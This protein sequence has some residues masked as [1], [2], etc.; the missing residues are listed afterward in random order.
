MDI[1]RSIITRTQV[2]KSTNSLPKT[3]RSIMAGPRE[4]SRHRRK[5]RQ[6]EHPLLNIQASH[7]RP[8]AEGSNEAGE[9]GFVRDHT[10]VPSAHSEDSYD[11][12]DHGHPLDSRA[13]RL[14]R[15]F[16]KTCKE[17]LVKHRMWILPATLTCILFVCGLWAF[18]RSAEPS[19]Y[20]TY[21]STITVTPSST[22]Y[23]TYTVHYKQFHEARPVHH[24]VPMAVPSNLEATGQVTGQDLS[25]PQIVTAT[26][27]PVSGLY[28]IP[29]SVASG[30]WPQTQKDSHPSSRSARNAEGSQTLQG[31]PSFG[32]S[33]PDDPLLLQLRGTPR[34]LFPGQAYADTT[35]FTR[36]GVEVLYELRRRSRRSIYFNKR[37]CI[38]SACSPEKILNSMCNTNKTIS[39]S[40]QKQEC[41]WCWPENQRKHQEINKHCSKVSKH[42]LNTMFI[43]CGIFLFCT[44]AIAIVLATRMLRRRRRAEA[45]C[46]LHKH[47]STIPQE[48]TNSAPSCWVSLDMTNSGR[49]SKAKKTRV[50]DKA[51]RKRS[52]GEAVG[53]KSWYKAVFAKWGKLSGTGPANPAHARLKLQKKETKPLD[54][55]FA[56]GDGDH[57]RVPVLP[58]AP[59][60]ISSQFF[61]D[62]ENMGQGSLR[63][64]PGI[65]NSQ[66]DPLVMPLRS[67][68]QSRAF[69]SGSEQSSSVATNR[70]DVG[71]GVYNLERLTERK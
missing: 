12:H 13:L 36:W 10:D 68:R 34:N 32:R 22:V 25:H 58:P 70:G 19:D 29:V 5:E 43:I 27:A 39:D 24:Q 69:S 64:D 57:E 50:D 55:D 67:S 3:R 56:I 1:H 54:Q 15:R 6:E 66:H 61:S 62:I 8:T 48:K 16:L 2:P 37:S 42:A 63:S 45:D 33:E 26:S 11:D 28:L 35:S 65:K 4:R 51:T 52:P 7:R 18:Y 23:I 59:P 44:L 17:G 53:Q 40:F 38:K 9:C 60:A 31:N 47:T 14:D 41:E 46:I 30:D 49:S 21:H 20:R 71:A